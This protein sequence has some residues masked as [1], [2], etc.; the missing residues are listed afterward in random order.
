MAPR[1]IFLPPC[2][3]NIIESM[4]YCCI[5]RPTLLCVNL[6]FTHWTGRKK[7]MQ[8]KKPRRG[9]QSVEI[10]FRILDVLQQSQQAMALKDLAPLAGLTASAANNYLVSLVRIGLAAGDEK[11]GH[12]RLGPAALSLGVSA[13]QQIDGFEIVRREVTSLR[14]TSGRSAPH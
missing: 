3:F 5:M 13:I 4:L 14:D 9:I 2:I 11:S 8:E 6:D 10:A 7:Q 1:G 12:Y